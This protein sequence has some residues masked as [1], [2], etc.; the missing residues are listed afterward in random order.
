MDTVGPA[1]CAVDV[2]ASVVRR[3]VVAYVGLAGGLTAWLSCGALAAGLFCGARCSCRCCCFCCCCKCFCC[4]TLWVRLQGSFVEL[5]A[6]VV[7]AGQ[8]YCGSSRPVCCGGEAQGT[9][10]HVLNIIIVGINAL[11]TCVRALRL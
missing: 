7:A 11:Y 5:V 4:W 6:D 3:A 9:S 2:V 8:R 1:D 10:T